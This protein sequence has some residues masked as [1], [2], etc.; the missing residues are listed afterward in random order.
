M[1]KDAMA[2]GTDSSKAP[3]SAASTKD[4]SKDASKAAPAKGANPAAT[5]GST[6][7]KGD[8]SAPMVVAKGPA[9]PTGQ[10]DRWQLMK[11]AMGRCAGET[12]FKRV[13][14]EQAV[15]LQY[16]EGYWGRVP[17]CPSGP[18]KDRGQ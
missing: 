16:C 3:G 1:T 15:G 9:S 17:Q 2:P 5:P 18:S 4:A 8:A 11:E 6:P 14:C 7:A 10:P 13:T 12:F